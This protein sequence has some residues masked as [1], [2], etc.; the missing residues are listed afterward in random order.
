VVDGQPVLPE[1]VL[2][3]NRYISTADQSFNSDL[4]AD[5]ARLNAIL[6]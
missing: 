6:V 5:A 2:I 4:P 3:V 1:V